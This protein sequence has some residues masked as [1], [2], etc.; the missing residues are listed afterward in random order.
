MS[1]Q[2]GTAGQPVAVDPLVEV[3][4]D[5]IKAELRP[6][7]HTA[8]AS[9]QP[10][11]NLASV[12]ADV[13][14]Q[15][16]D[17]IAAAVRAHLAEALAAPAVVEAELT[18]QEWRDIW[19]ASVRHGSWG[20]RQAINRIIA[21]RLAAVRAVLGAETSCPCTC[22]VEDRNRKAHGR[23]ERHSCTCPGR[24]EDEQCDCRYCLTVLLALAELRITNLRTELAVLGAETDE[25]AG[26]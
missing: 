19:G 2:T 22:C 16:L 18:D 10:W 26:R 17:N 14:P 7:V 6:V 20:E 24:A 25:A 13:W 12:R 15:V 1:A 5:A 23:D 4:H 21:K 9:A 11:V 3:I 8:L